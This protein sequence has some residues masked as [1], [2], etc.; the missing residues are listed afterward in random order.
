MEKRICRNGELELSVLGLGCWSFGGGD[1]WGE[2]DQKDTNAIVHASI[3]HGINYF[4]TAELY[5]DGRSEISLGQALKEV[6]R[7]QVI[8]GSKISPANCQPTVLIQHCE[9]SLSRLNTDY[10]DLYMIHWPVNSRSIASFSNDEYIINHPPA[11]D[12]VYEALQQLKQA[13][14]I[15]HIG[16]SN[17]SKTLMQAFPEISEI[18]VNQLPYSLISRAIEFD[19][20][21]FCENNGIGV[22][23]YMGL[24]QGILADRYPTFDDIPPQRRR[25]RHF[26]DKR[27]PACRHGEEGC[28]PEL[29]QALQDLRKIGKES[30][31]PMAD[32]AIKWI[33]ANP[34]VT[35]NLVGASSVRQVEANAKALEEPLST[36]AVQALN[37]ATQAV[38][39]A[40]GNHLDYFEG[41]AND[42][43]I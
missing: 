21:P 11:I 22:M 36:E 34:A 5:N 42:R 24:M 3:D 16:I 17:F 4:D 43:T 30:G 18:A 29:K 23:G 26:D 41:V 12:E 27:T 32:L 31:Y 28:E 1:Y 37:K 7:D 35:C 2:R 14:K 13:G 38:K 39:T 19:A 6:P 33:F 15:R 10:L 25:T 9:A 20:L 40:L 8:I